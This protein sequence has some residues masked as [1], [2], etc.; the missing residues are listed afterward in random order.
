MVLGL[1]TATGTAG[2]GLLLQQPAGPRPRREHPLY[3]AAYGDQ[4]GGKAHP[5][6][7]VLHSDSPFPCGQ[8]SCPLHPSG[9]QRSV[10]RSQRDQLAAFPARRFCSASHPP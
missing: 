2:Q 6:G 7:W 10:T 4:L 9:E 5:E 3:S 1:T 8:S